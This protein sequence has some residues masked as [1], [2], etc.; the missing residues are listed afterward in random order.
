MLLQDG[1]CQ[2]KIKMYIHDT[3]DLLSKATI[4]YTINF[5]NDQ[6]PQRYGSGA[7]RWFH[8]KPRTSTESILINQLKSA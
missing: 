1:L 6:F 3:E 5:D 8:A 7:Q 2:I 4:T